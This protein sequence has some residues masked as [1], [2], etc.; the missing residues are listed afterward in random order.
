MRIRNKRETVESTQKVSLYTLY[1]ITKIREGNMNKKKEA[2]LKERAMSIKRAINSGEEVNVPNPPGEKKSILDLMIDFTTGKLGVDFEVLKK[3]LGT[4]VK[5]YL[6]A[7]ESKTFQWLLF[8]VL[9]GNYYRKTMLHFGN[10]TKEEHKELKTGITH[11]TNYCDLVLNRLDEQQMDGLIKRCDGAGIRIFDQPTLRKLLVATNHSMSHVMI[12]R[13]DMEFFSE[14]IMHQYCRNCTVEFSV[15]R[16]FRGLSESFIPESGHNC[17]NCPYAYTDTNPEFNTTRH[18]HALTEIRAEKASLLNN[19]KLKP[20]GE[21]LTNEIAALD[22]A[23]ELLVE[24]KG[25]IKTHPMREQFFEILEKR[26]YDMPAREVL[27]EKIER[28]VR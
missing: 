16:I 10:I 26:E 12:D 13:V 15:C 5:R 18:I 2:E 7:E 28:Y 14:L 19:E 1:F 22:K 23:I 11:L 20:I 17:P 24:S 25:D 8:T 3:N 6:N 4:N 27:K 9:Y 21:Q